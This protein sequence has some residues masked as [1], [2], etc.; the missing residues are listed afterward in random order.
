MQIQVTDDICENIAALAAKYGLKLVLLFGSQ[1]RG[2]THEE[3]DV[4]VA[5]LGERLLTEGEMITINYECTLI[6]RTND[7][8]TTNL[9]CAS[10]LLQRRIIDEAEVLYDKTGHEYSAFESAAIQRYAEAGPLYA[11][12]RE[13]NKAFL[14]TL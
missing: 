4:D 14:E 10:P 1:A 8:D 3:S 9:S 2:E 12:T 6:F 13:K 7:V 11:I 5:V